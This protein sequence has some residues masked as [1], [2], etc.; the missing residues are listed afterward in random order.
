MDAEFRRALDIILEVMKAN[1]APDADDAGAVRWAVLS[2][3][4]CV[5]TGA[6]VVN[7]AMLAAL[8]AQQTAVVLSAVFNR[9]VEAELQDDGR[10]VFVS[11]GQ[12]VADADCW[13]PATVQ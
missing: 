13:Q 12:M 2:H 10:F 11:D 8:Q 9:A 7:D 4:H 3:A 1:E 6:V 5:E